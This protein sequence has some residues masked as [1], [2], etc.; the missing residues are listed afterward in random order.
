MDY[1]K[2][3]IFFISIVIVVFGYLMFIN[4]TNTSP[5]GECPPGEPD[6][7]GTINDDPFIQDGPLLE[8]DGIDTPISEGPPTLV[9]EMDGVS[10]S[11]TELIP[12]GGCPSDEP[13]CLDV[14]D[15]PTLQGD[16]ID[17]PVL[18]GPPTL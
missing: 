16:G 18:E 3:A 7:I 1:K 11:N 8:G 14:L 2:L 4:K 6:C 17:A 9:E 13:D 10:S 15:D 5:Q 12:P